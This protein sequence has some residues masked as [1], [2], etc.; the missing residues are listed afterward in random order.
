MR[1]TPHPLHARLQ[2]D[3]ECRFV[4]GQQMHLSLIFLDTNLS[5]SLLKL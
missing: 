5:S 2:V 1:Q 4:S 3:G